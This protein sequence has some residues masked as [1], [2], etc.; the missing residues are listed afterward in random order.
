MR[1]ECDGSSVVSTAVAARDWVSDTVFAFWHAAIVVATHASGLGW[2]LT[3][4]GPTLIL[5]SL[6]FSFS[7]SRSLSSFLSVSGCF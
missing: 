6:S 5:Q 7:L 3:L 2:Q 1:A 4:A